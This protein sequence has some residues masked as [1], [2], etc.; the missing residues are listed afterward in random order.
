[1]LVP[2]LGLLRFDLIVQHVAVVREVQILLAE[3]EQYQTDGE[4]SEESDGDLDLGGPNPAKEPALTEVP[5][6][7]RG[8]RFGR[9]F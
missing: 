7:D 1:M 4:G 6:I 9:H 5:S 3:F 8:D 2:E